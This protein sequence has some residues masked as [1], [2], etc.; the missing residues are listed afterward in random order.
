MG[1]DVHGGMHR[2]LQARQRHPDCYWSKSLDA[3]SY[4]GFSPGAQRRPALYGESIQA[5][6]REGIDTS[7]WPT[8]S[9]D[10]NPKE[11]LWDIMFQSMFCF[12]PRV[13]FSIEGSRFP[14]SQRKRLRCS[15]RDACPTLS[16]TY[17]S[18][19]I[20]NSIQ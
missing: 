19:K 14:G 12:L 15:L 17:G 4:P 18:G 6:H 2:P 11:H 3:L 20:N 10:L 9:P 5:V 16:W 13:H 1:R 8:C 7:Y